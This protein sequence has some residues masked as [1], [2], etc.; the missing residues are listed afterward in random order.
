MR[1]TQTQSQ[2]LFDFF[3]FYIL[4][5][6]PPF[7]FIPLKLTEHNELNER[8]GDFL[9]DVSCHTIVEPSIDRL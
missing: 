5:S 3:Q 8:T 6:F 2:S 7:Y 9:D 4:P 1:I